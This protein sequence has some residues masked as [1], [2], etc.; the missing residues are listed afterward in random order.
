MVCGLKFTFLLIL[1]LEKPFF[2]VVFTERMKSRRESPPSSYGVASLHPV[3]N[4]NKSEDKSGV[5]LGIMSLLKHGQG[6]A[7]VTRRL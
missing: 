1:V 2:L 5:L 6:S 4:K 7:K 3:E